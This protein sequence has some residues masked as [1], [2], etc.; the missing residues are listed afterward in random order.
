MAEREEISRGLAK[1]RSAREIAATLG[2]SPSTIAREVARN[3]GR[4]A[5]RAA[6]AD[7]RAYQR[8]RRPKFAKLARNPLL[9]VLVEE[10]L[11]V[12]W[13]VL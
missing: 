7:H 3:G 2:R 12:C 6:M 11:A 8:A 4:T 13:T 9:R 5:Y 10:K 1:G